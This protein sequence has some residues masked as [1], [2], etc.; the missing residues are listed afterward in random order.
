MSFLVQRLT[1]YRIDLGYEELYRKMPWGSNWQIV[2]V[3]ALLQTTASDSIVMPPPVVF[4]NPFFSLGLCTGNYGFLTPAAQMAK[5]DAL[6]LGLG[7]SA[8]WTSNWIIQ[9]VNSNPVLA[10]PGVYFTTIQKLGAAFPNTNSAAG[11]AYGWYLGAVV[12]PGAPSLCRMPVVID[13]TKGSFG[14]GNPASYTFQFWCPSG[15]ATAN[16]ADVTQATFFDRIQPFNSVANTTGISGSMSVSGSMLHD[17]VCVSW[18][19]AW[20]LLE[21]S[22]LVVIR[23][24]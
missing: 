2:R 6:G 14:G 15:N 23:Y 19:K 17:T 7:N 9:A 20:P 24:A 10:T 11:G 8:A 16:V 12:S 21:I 22:E 3:A 13:W 4:P 5:V 1:D 18:Q